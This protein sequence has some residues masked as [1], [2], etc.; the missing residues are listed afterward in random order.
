MA[1][2]LDE[3]AGENAAEQPAEGKCRHGGTGRPCLAR[4]RQFEWHIGRH[5]AAANGGDRHRDDDAGDRE[6]RSR[7]VSLPLG[8]MSVARLTDLRLT[9]HASAPDLCHQCVIMGV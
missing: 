3:R 5:D 2:A 8:C 9:V 1:D 4:A 6:R 7:C